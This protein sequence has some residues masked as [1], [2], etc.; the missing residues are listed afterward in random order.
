MT[1]FELKPLR[2]AR[3]LC[4]HGLVAARLLPLQT[5]HLDDKVDMAEWE[6]LYL[7]T[8]WGDVLPKFSLPRQNTD[9]MCQLLEMAIGTELSVLRQDS[10]ALATTTRD[11]FSR[12]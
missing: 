4:C 1:V 6:R 11:L 5:L 12:A 3:G 2:F 10:W 9:G 7:Q 8:G